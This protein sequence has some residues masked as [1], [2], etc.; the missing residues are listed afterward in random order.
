M[1]KHGIASRFKEVVECQKIIDKESACTIASGT[2]EN[3]VVNLDR[4]EM[5]WAEITVAGLPSCWGPT[6]TVLL[7]LPTYETRLK[8]ELN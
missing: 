3:V 8:E 6:P 5:I 2:L 4:F 7:P 1:E